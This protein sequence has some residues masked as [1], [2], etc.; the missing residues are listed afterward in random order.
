MRCQ[1]LVPSSISFKD[2][3]SFDMETLIKNRPACPRCGDMTSYDKKNICIRD[4]SGEF[5][6]IDIKWE[7]TISQPPR[8]PQRFRWGA[9]LNHRLKRGRGGET[10]PPKKSMGIERRLHP[11]ILVKWPAVVETPRGS[12]EGETKDISV[13]G[14][15]IFCSKEPE[16]GENF[17]II[18]KPSEQ[19]TISIVGEKIWSGSFTIDNRTVF[20]MGVQFIQISPEDRNYIA[21]LVEKSSNE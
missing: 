11:R 13:D 10:V 8:Y 4:E 20:G 6:C 7:Q 12:V 19:R 21:V 3:K 2:K 15:F 18:L 14:V 9:S 1:E 17:T 16:I 5:V